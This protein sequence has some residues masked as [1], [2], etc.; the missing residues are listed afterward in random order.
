MTVRLPVV[1]A[2]LHRT[3]LDSVAGEA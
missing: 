3:P 1:S 2:T